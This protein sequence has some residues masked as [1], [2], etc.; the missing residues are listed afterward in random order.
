MDLY[1]KL[2]IIEIISSYTP[3]K[4]KGHYYWG[5]CPFHTDLKPSLSVNPTK[6]TFK[7]FACGTNGDVITFLSKIHKKSRKEIFEML[8][9]QKEL[10]ES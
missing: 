8:K 7:C 4:K 5:C 2:D 9:I 10:E 3:L 6:G 1:P